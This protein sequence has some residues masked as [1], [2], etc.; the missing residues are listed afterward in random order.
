[1]K[2]IHNQ[3][4]VCF[5]VMILKNGQKYWYQFIINSPF[6]PIC[7]VWE[8]LSLSREWRIK[9]CIGRSQWLLIN[10]QL[11]LKEIWTLYQIQHKSHSCV[12]EVTCLWE[13]DRRHNA[14]VVASAEMLMDTIAQYTI[15]AYKG[16]FMAA[17]LSQNKLETTFP[18]G[19]W[20]QSSWPHVIIFRE[21]EK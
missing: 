21:L 9:L 20:W 8:I 14:T 13:R 2:Y 7:H 16:A 6:N 17:N 3:P 15:Q 5:W 10:N 19:V 1:M 18:W 4:I 12:P 11:F